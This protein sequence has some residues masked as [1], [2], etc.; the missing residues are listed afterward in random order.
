MFSFADVHA[1]YRVRLHIE[2][3][4][5]EIKQA[6]GGDN[7]RLRHKI[8]VINHIYMML[9]AYLISK[10]F[11]NR[12]AIANRKTLNAIMIDICMKDTLRFEFIEIV[13]FLIVNPYISK[14]KLKEISE[15]FCD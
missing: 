8:S 11:L 10:Y 1:L 2:E 7:L 4:F 15:H 12:I 14:C 3:M 9:I 13:L 5:R 6:F